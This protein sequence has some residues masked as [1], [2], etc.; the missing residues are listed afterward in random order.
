MIQ[1]VVLYWLKDRENQALVEETLEK[2]R[3]MEGKIP[4]L[5]RLHAGRDVVRSPRSCDICL[6]TLFE[7]QE[8]LE[9]YRSHPLHLPVQAHV[10]SVV[11][12]SASADIEVDGL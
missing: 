4:G 3:S 10:H 6:S 1:H 2:F 8:A 7:S 5:L 9:A 11:E 12:R